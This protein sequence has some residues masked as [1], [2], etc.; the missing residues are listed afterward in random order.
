MTVLAILKSSLLTWCALGIGMVH[1]STEQC[2]SVVFQNSQGGTPWNKE[3][4]S[5][6]ERFVSFKAWQTLPMFLFTLCAI[7]CPSGE[8]ELAT[9][10]KNLG[11]ILTLVDQNGFPCRSADWEA[12]GVFW[13]TCFQ[14]SCCSRGQGV[15]RKTKLHVARNYLGMIFDGRWGKEEF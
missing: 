8:G 6:E 2:W 4:L 11:V 3:K 7:R 10:F 14:T 12:E 5:G 15:T 13:P 9:G 1:G